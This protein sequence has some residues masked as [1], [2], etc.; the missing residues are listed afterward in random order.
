LVLRAAT[1]AFQKQQSASTRPLLGC[2]FSALQKPQLK[3]WATAFG[4]L[5]M[6]Q[7]QA[8]WRV[9]IM[10][11]RGLTLCWGLQRQAVQAV[12]A[13]HHL[14]VQAVQAVVV[15]VIQS[16]GLC[17]AGGWLLLTQHWQLQPLMH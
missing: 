9:C 6:Q 15:V 7:Q 5:T 2:T 10:A 13:M 17:T 12:Q 4:F 16:V 14:A 1:A 3:A 8:V 11:S